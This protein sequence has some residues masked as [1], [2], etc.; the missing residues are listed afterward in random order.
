MNIEITGNL[1]LIKEGKMFELFGTVQTVRGFYNLFGK[2]FNLNSGTLT[3]R[4]GETLNPE[5]DLDAQYKFRDIEKEKQTLNLLI[6]GTLS[7]PEIQFRLNDKPIS[8]TDGLSYLLFGRS[9]AQ[10]SHGERQQVSQSSSQTGTA[11]MTRLLSGQLTQ[12]VSRIAQDKLN[13]D[14][15]RISGDAN[16]RNTALTVGKYLT[17]DLF[18]RYERELSFGSSKETIP[19]ELFLEYEINRHLF[20]Q[21]VKGDPQT[22]GF[23]II[24]KF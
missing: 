3:F 16:W 17:N 2:R 20:L 18:L 15:I 12:Q 13:L 22:T 10:L 8:E 24:I 1:N 14:L 23:D 6:T 19:Q 9:G 5:L 7:F 21:A 4:G 11:A